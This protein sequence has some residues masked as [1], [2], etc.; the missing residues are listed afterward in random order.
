[1]VYR[2]SDIVYR[3]DGDC[4]VYYEMDVRFPVGSETS[5]EKIRTVVCPDVIVVCDR[6]QVD[7]FCCVGAPDLVI[8][9]QSPS[10]SHRDL[11]YKYELYE[12]EGVREYWVVYPLDRCIR[13]FTLSA[14]GKYGDGVLYESGVVPVGIFGGAGIELSDIFK[15]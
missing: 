4:E 11:H 1:L 6:N 9:I 2:L 13:V 8:E 12:R 3:G 5:A 14:D 10:T 7:E 15:Q